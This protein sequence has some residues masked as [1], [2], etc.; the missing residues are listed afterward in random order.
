MVCTRATHTL[1][2]DYFIT[3]NI[4]VSNNYKGAEGCLDNVVLLPKASLIQY[5]LYYSRGL[6]HKHD[7]LQ[8]HQFD[9]YLDSEL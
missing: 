7:F 1:R 9:L 3:V 8:T 6:L 5:T 2:A 4:V